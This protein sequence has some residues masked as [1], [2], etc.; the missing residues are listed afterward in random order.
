MTGAW[1]FTMHIPGFEEGQTI[2]IRGFDRTNKGKKRAW[3]KAKWY[4]DFASSIGAGSY[5]I[6]CEWQEE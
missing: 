4:C 2:F 5:T 6:E 1:K 3:K